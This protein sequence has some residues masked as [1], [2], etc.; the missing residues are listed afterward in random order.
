MTP[1]SSSTVATGTQYKFF[2]TITNTLPDDVD[3]V[4]IPIRVTRTGNARITGALS[5]RSPAQFGAEVVTLT[6]LALVVVRAPAA[7]VSVFDVNLN[8]DGLGTLL[9]EVGEC[10]GTLPNDNPAPIVVDTPALP[11]ITLQVSSG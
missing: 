8:V 10:S 7:E 2:L 4:D 11:T 5:S 3:E 1:V 9:L 6:L